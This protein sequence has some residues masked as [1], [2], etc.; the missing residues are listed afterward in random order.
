M[1]PHGTS[2]T[3]WWVGGTRA[4]APPTGYQSAG[5][6]WRR[7]KAVPLDPRITAFT[8]AILGRGR[9]P[10]E[11]GV[12][13]C[14]IRRAR[15]TQTFVSRLGLIERGGS[16]AGSRVAWDSYTAFN[17]LV[18]PA[19]IETTG[20]RAVSPHEKGRFSRC[21]SGPG[22]ADVTKGELS[23]SSCKVNPESA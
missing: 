16:A 20:N 4:R 7:W 22:Q 14:G 1:N 21:L 2:P 15:R 10:F 12:G 6:K 17:P 11:A 3:C 8:V 19:A 5:F 13:S 9:T 18:L 23:Q